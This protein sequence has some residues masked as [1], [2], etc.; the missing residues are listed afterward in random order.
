MLCFATKLNLEQTFSVQRYHRPKLSCYLNCRAKLVRQ[1]HIPL[2]KWNPPPTAAQNANWTSAGIR[3]LNCASLDDV[4]SRERARL[5]QTWAA[6]LRC[7]FPALGFPLCCPARFCSRPEFKGSRRRR[8]I[9]APKQGGCECRL[10]IGFVSLCVYVCMRT[11]AQQISCCRACVS[12]KIRKRVHWLGKY[13]RKVW[14][15]A[16][17]P[18]ICFQIERYSSIQDLWAQN[19]DLHLQIYI[20]MVVVNMYQS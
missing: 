20:Y 4:Y 8:E 12:N 18:F 1:K 14:C 3:Y 2:R 5:E 11:Y 7:F 13:Y 16:R 19:L 6:R 15:T 9:N 17:F 10:D